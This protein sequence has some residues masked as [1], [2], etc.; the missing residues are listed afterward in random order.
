M[1]GEDD[2]VAIGQSVEPFTLPDIVSGQEV[3]L[4][5]YL[6]KQE[7]VIVS[8]MG[9]FCVGCEE[10]LAELQER[11]GDFSSR[12]ATLLVLGSK[13]ES[14]DVGR[15][16]AEEHGITYPILHDAGTS[17]TRNVGL[18]SDSMQ[19]PLMG[20]VVIDRSRRIAAADQVLSEVRGAAPANIDEILSALDRVQTDNVAAGG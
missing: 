20:Y 16:K 10:L 6:G 19:M 1:G 7:I 9:F 18:W 2:P 13:P 8:Y 14:V 17:V 15:A 4:G 11:Q 12:G 5:D 3:S